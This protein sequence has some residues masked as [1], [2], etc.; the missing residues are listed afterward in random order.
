[1][2][3]L[4]LPAAVVARIRAHARRA[5][6]EECCGVLVGRGRRVERSVKAANAAEGQRTRRYTIDP[7]VLLAIHKEA[8]QTHREVVGYYHSH[9]GRPARPSAYD[10]EHAWPE[11]S[12]LIVALEDGRVVELRSWRIRPGDGRF[13][14]EPCRARRRS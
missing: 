12:Y 7:E 3:E 11:A 9:P 6:P 14:E 2:A 13:E 8:R 5:Y 10:L 1:M 4:L